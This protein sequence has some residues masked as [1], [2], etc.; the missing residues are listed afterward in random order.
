MYL[1]P[2][3]SKSHA[4]TV[5]VLLPLWY[6]IFFF[7]IFSVGCIILFVITCNAA[8]MSIY[9]ASTNSLLKSLQNCSKGGVD[10]ANRSLQRGDFV[11]GVNLNCLQLTKAVISNTNILIKCICVQ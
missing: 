8:H 10:Y 4:M 5:I 11:V 3:W 7:P 6:N 1:S 9:W 2:W